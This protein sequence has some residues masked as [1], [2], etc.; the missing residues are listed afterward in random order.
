MASGLLPPVARQDATLNC[1]SPLCLKPLN[2]SRLARAALIAALLVAT[3]ELAVRSLFDIKLYGADAEVGYWALP[4]QSGGSPLTGSY[5]FNSEGF[6][7]SQEYDTSGPK[8]VLLVGDSLVAGTSELD[9]SERLGVALERQ[10]GW[11]VWPLATGSW[12]LANELRA[13]TRI[14]LD[15]VEAI[16]FVLNSEDFDAPSQWRGD[17]DLPRAQPR[18]HFLHALQ[19]AI[20][21]LR[22]PSEP[23][24]VREG[25]LAAEW[26]SFQ[27]AA[28]TLVFVVGYEWKKTTGQ[29]CEWMP[30]WIE[31]VS[32]CVDLIGTGHGE[33]MLD[34]MH[35]DARG[36]E[37]IAK[38]IAARLAT[39][40]KA[41]AARGVAN[42][43]VLSDAG[44]IR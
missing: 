23:I 8:D 18:S 20:P 44:T 28:E 38:T 7:V 13:L 5:A 33:N 22:G 1:R 15:G 30:E 29:D 10:S 40:P 36:N 19:K 25:N 3:G 14:D 42:D 6:G 21:F 24:L 9:Q 35:P 17:H 16:V 12:A 31:P 41:E 11:Q 37:V 27:A 4:N 34:A 26:S 39:W 43:R 2:M 32:L